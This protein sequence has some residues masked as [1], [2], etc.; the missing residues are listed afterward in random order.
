MNKV[1]QSWRY[2]AWADELDFV[3]PR[4]RT[5]PWAWAIL[6]CGLLAAAWTWTCVSRL[7]NDLAD[8]QQVVKRLQRAAHQAQVNSMASRQTGTAGSTAP[9][10]TPD[11]ARHAAQLAQFLSYPWVSVMERVE[12]SAKAEQAVMLSFSLDLAPLATQAQAA[13]E[14]RVVAAIKDDDAALR[15]AHAQGTSAQLLNRER[16]AAPFVTAVGRYDWRAEASWPG[17]QP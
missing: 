14:V 17:A 4:V 7:D 6:L 1:W 10:L 11:A 15:W 12:Q 16:L 3:G 13:P 9:A 5:A 8:A 2:P